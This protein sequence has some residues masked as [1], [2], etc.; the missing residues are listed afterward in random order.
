MRI[1]MGPVAAG[2]ALVVGL[3]GPARAEAAA[4]TEVPEQTEPEETEEEQ[5][6]R[7]RAQRRLERMGI[8]HLVA[9]TRTVAVGRNEEGETLRAPEFRARVTAPTLAYLH[10]LSDATGGLPEFRSPFYF[11]LRR[12]GAVEI[13][14]TTGGEI[15][16]LTRAPTGLHLYA[17]ERLPKGIRI[18]EIQSRN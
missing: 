15:V 18:Y 10:G 12:S 6:A 4:A 16:G 3:A 7:F 11:V 13:R 2:V 17:E 9:T 14:S 8:R 1:A 5:R